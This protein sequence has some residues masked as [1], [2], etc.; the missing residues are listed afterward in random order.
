KVPGCHRCDGGKI[1]QRKATTGPLLLWTNSRPVAEHIHV[2]GRPRLT[3]VLLKYAGRENRLIFVGLLLKARQPNRQPSLI[4]ERVQAAQGIQMVLSDEFE[5]IFKCDDNRGIHP[6]FRRTS[7][8][9]DKLH[10]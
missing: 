7:Q 8:F 3:Y 2:T 6:W 10:V 1:D 4:L 9:I 5:S